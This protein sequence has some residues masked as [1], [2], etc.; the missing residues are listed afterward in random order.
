MTVNPNSLNELLSSPMV[1]TIHED[2]VR[3]LSMDLTI[4]QVG[5]DD[6]V[7]AGFD[8]SGQAV[9]I[10]DTGVDT[11]HDFLEVVKL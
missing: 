6:V 5:A 7:A 11:T 8:G 9:A 3:T 2:K 1:K 10:L 4:P